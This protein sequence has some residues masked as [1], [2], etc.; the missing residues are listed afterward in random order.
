MLAVNAMIYKIIDNLYYYVV[1]F[2]LKVLVHIEILKILPLK[3]ISIHKLKI[4]II[5]EN[6]MGVA[7]AED[8]KY[9]H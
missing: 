8:Q 2:E 5:H 6:C 3:H 4:Y 1:Y 7:S 9:E